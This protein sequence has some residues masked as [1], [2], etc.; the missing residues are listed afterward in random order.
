MKRE[1][2]IGIFTILMIVVAWG[3][4]RFLSGIDLFNANND[5][6]AKYDQISGIQQASPIFIRGVKIGSVTGLALDSSNNSS[7]VELQLTISAKYQI[8]TDSE[9]KIFSCGIMGPMAIEIVMGKSSEFLE[10]GDDITSGRNPDLFDSAGSELGSLKKRVDSL[11]IDLSLTLANLNTLMVNNS[12]NIHG[13]LSNMNELSKNLNSLL[14]KN[15]Q[16]ITTMVSGLSKLSESLGNNTPA[17]DSIIL[18]VNTLTRDLSEAK[19]GDA[20]TKSLSQVDEVMAKL[21]DTNGTAGLLL[22]DEALY[23]NLSTA[24]ANLD[25]LFVDLKQNPSRYVNI[26]VF[27]KNEDKQRAKAEKRAYKAKEKAL[28]DEAQK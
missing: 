18:N 24:S 19:L 10:S 23:N 4:I 15:E 25:S 28:K 22:E 5:Y 6:Y 27:G 11:A 16:G 20:I 1:I 13:T 14:V 8:P 17:I 3:G 7:S 21:N 2:K 12:E 26:S 9:A